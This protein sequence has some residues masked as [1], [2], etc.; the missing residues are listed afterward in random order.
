MKRLHMGVRK[1]LR[2]GRGS[3]GGPQAAPAHASVGLMH[4]HLRVLHVCVHST[5][6]FSIYS[7]KERDTLVAVLRHFR[8]CSQGRDL[9]NHVLT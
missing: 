6:L 1:T 2:R 4:G 3:D 5:R 8:R 9:Q 7:P